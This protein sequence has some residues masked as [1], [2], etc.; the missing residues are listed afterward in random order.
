MSGSQIINSGILCSLVLKGNS[1]K[2]E[3]ATSLHGSPEIRRLTVIATQ[4]CAHRTIHCACT[5]S[6]HAGLPFNDMFPVTT[7][8]GF[9]CII[10]CTQLFDFYSLLIFNFDLLL[11]GVNFN[12]LNCFLH[13]ICG[14]WLNNLR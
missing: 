9:V 6:K 5:K 13:S 4:A 7:F 11:F 10:S 3:R 8:R 12:L 2:P 14:I 1:E